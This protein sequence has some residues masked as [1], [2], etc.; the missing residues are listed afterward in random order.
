MKN[1]PDYRL[2]I[3][4]L[5]GAAYIVEPGASGACIYMSPAIEDL[6]GYPA[7]R[8]ENDPLHWAE[9][10]HGDDLDRVIQDAGDEAHARTIEYRMIRADGETIWVCDR[11]VPVINDDGSWVRQGV[12][13]DISER[14]HRKELAERTRFHDISAVLR[15]EEESEGRKEVLE[16]LPVAVWITDRDLN[17][18]SAAGGGVEMFDLGPPGDRLTIRDVALD[19]SDPKKVIDA[20][21]EALEGEIVL[22]TLTGF[23]DRRQICEVA[24]FRR[25]GAIV[26][27]I[28]VTMDVTTLDLSAETLDTWGTSL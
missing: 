4:E 9:S 26:G 13:Q 12:L 18:I 19:L 5:W 6:T 10:I 24:P 21:K 14:K 22:Y 16:Q 2:M 1:E 25:K 27:V 11:S 8:W 20:H 23:G 7:R 3:D 15:V 28:G 17:I